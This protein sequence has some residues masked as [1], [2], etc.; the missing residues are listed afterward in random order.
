MSRHLPS[1]IL[2]ALAAVFLAASGQTAFGSVGATTPFTTFEAEAGTLGGG[3]AVV[4]LTSSP[5][6][7]YSSPQLE[8]SG[9]AYVQLTATGQYVQWTNNTTQSF[10]AINLR[11]CIPDAS[12]GGGITSTIDLYVNGT[13]RQALSVN[14]QQNYCYEGKN[15]NDQTDKNPADG[16]PRDFWNDTHAFITGATVSPGQTI[17]I[18]MDSTNTAAFYYVDCIDLETPPAASTQPANSLSITSYGAMANNSTIDNTAAINSCFTAAQSQNK[19]AWIPSGI[20]YFSADK[21]GLKATN[22]TIEGAGPWYSTIYRVTPANN[23]QGVC[24]II[25]TSGCT[26]QNLSLDCNSNSRN[27]VNNNGAVNFS[28]SNW[29][30]NNCWVQH[31]TSGFWCGGDGGTIENCRV[32]DTWADGMNLNNVQDSRGVGNNLTAQNNFVRGSGDDATAINSVN[33]NGTTFYTQMSNIT[34][35]NNTS[36][37]PWGGKGLGMYGGNNVVATNCY[38]SDT[39]RYIGLG[40]MRFGV[41]GSDLTSGTVTGNVVERCGGN[42]YLQQQSAMM[43]GNGG[44]GQSVGQVQNVLVGDNVIDDALYNAVSFTTSKSITFQ[45][46][47]I[48]NPSLNAIFIGA[49][50]FGYNILDANSVTGLPSGESEIANSSSTAYTMTN[51]EEGEFLTVNQITSGL[52]NTIITSSS[53]SNGE[54]AFLNSNAV[55]NSVTY[56]IP[57]IQAGSYRVFVGTKTHFSRGIWQLAVAKV[58]AGFTNQGTPVDAYTAS[59][60]YTNFNLG[61]WSPATTSDKL[62]RFTITGKNSASSGY[63]AAFDYFALVPLLTTNYEPEYLPETNSSGVTV[64]VETDSAAY[65]DAWS[66]VTPSAAGQSITYTVG[67]N[68]VLNETYSVAVGMKVATNRGIY[69]LSV[70]GNNVGSPVDEYSTTSGYTTVNL[71][72]FTAN[73]NA[74]QPFT[75]TCTGK[76]S[77]STSFELSFDYIALTPQ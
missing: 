76:N 62:F 26:M 58:G 50:H 46:N 35:Q 12:A 56:L 16:D 31:V 21:G 69:Q 19:I 63:D 13:F 44:D 27:G 20:F 42:A 41:N 15:Y 29:V 65:D 17:R 11:S 64:T 70:N 37:A 24:N 55:G 2:S 3:A 30:V 28:G 53:F 52:T 43:I 48:S 54:A 7:Q 34:M 39:A 72:T 36:I 47:T 59:D 6:T 32:Q 67:N 33:Y 77:S 57:T 73:G 14:S 60:A 8:A 10:T 1:T 74:T 61:A 4:A 71:G 68:L 75:F 23:G 51:W 49:N 22:I 66:H 40:V 25:T 38:M 9:H 5:T 18:Q 45:Q